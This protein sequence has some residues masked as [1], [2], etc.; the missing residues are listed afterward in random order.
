[1]DQPPGLPIMV[2]GKVNTAETIVCTRR[3]DVK[4]IHGRYAAA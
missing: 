3:L 1:M 2:P 4:E